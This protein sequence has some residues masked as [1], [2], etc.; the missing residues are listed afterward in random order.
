MSLRLRDAVSFFRLIAWLLAI[1]A[2]VPH[3][4]SAQIRG[5]PPR[6]APSSTGW[7]LSGGAG[8]MVIGTIADGRSQSRWEF[9]NDPLWQYRASIEKVLDPFTTLGISA[10]FGEV[11]LRI[12]PLGPDS[13]AALPSVCQT[14]CAASAE[15]WTVM[16][17]FRS[18][19]GTGFHTLFEASGGGT[20]FRNFQTKTDAIALAGIP[21]SFDLSGTLGAGFAYPLSNTMVISL[22]QDFGIGF[23]AA[24]DLPEGTGRTWRVRT[25]RASLR[26][27][28]GGR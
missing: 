7:W 2:V 10:G 11:P 12:A 24:T 13:S 17:Q 8:A 28:F 5:A 20:L 22:V 21:R 14:A 23:H 27:K 3:D 26:L 15:L 19:G 1:G 6:P 25:T 16:A 18:G 9:G 4:V